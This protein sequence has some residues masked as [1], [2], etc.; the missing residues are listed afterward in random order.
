LNSKPKGKTASDIKQQELYSP[1]NQFYKWRKHDLKGKSFTIFWSKGA[2]ECAFSSPFFNSSS[3]FSDKLVAGAQVTKVDYIIA[4][5]LNNR[6]LLPRTIHF[7]LCYSAQVL[8]NLVFRTVKY[9]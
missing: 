6:V 9:L 5:R 2:T 1:L 7:I 3:F 4:S 8:V